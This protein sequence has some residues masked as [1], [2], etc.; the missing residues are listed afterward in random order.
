LEF[1]VKTSSVISDSLS[2]NTEIDFWVLRSS[3]IV[4]DNT[5]WIASCT[6]TNI[7]KEIHTFIGKAFSSDLSDFFDVTFGIRGND[8]PGL[9]SH[10]NRVSDRTSFSAVVLRN[11]V[12]MS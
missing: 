7:V 8:L 11:Q 9:I 1:D 10:P 12:S 4:N 6:L 5:N 2:N 3:L